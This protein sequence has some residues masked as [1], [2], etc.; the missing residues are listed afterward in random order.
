[1][2]TICL[3]SNSTRIQEAVELLQMILIAPAGKRRRM[4]VIEADT[5]MH[6]R[7]PLQD[8]HNVEIREVRSENEQIAI[9]LQSGLELLLPVKPLV[10]GSGIVNQNPTRID[11]TSNSVSIV[12]P[13]FFFE[14]RRR[15]DFMKWCFV[16]PRDMDDE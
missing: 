13:Y 14:D 5:A 6:P 9:T 3:V 8:A 7:E 1:M 4:V 15:V 12:K 10:F 16:S 11:Y 2:P